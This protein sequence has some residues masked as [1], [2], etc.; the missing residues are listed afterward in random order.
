M[1]TNWN[2]IYGQSIVKEILNNIINSSKIP[3]AILFSG[4]EGTGKDF[5]AVR[6]A[7]ALNLKFLNFD[8][9]QHVNNLISNFSEPYIKYIFPL[10]RGKNESDTTGPMEKLSLDEIQVIKEELSKK[11]QNPYRK[12]KIPRASN[13]K[14]SSIRDIKKFLS[15]DYS[16]VVY[17]IVLIS[18][19]HL[20]NEEA[21]NALLKSLEEPPE[22]V[23][24]ILT[25]PFPNILRETIRSRCWV[26]NFQPLSNEDLTKILISHF[27]FERSLAVKIAPF[28][29]GSV[30]NALML[31]ENEFED[32]LEK[33]ILILRYSF[34]KKF[35]SALNEFAE[36]LADNN[37]ELIKLLINMIIIWL[38]D[39]QKYRYGN[40]NIYFRDY[41]ETIQKF[42]KRFP[43]VSINR[44]VSKLENLA[45]VIRNNINLNLIV[46]NI[47][48]EISIL[49]FPV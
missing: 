20:M 48:Y 1:S 16:D 8:K 18:D 47:V 19:A 42:N 40:E 41:V 24:F 32:L 45:S 39:V 22:G 46:L 12:L 23:I 43:D 36:L 30:N 3:H 14:I 5:T 28:S 38:N 6:F 21:Q 26:I 35:H 31:L 49:T 27:N 4:I 17:R 7:Q 25:T 44:L 33:T 34:G 15:Y 13:I 29:G 10:P 2:G 9:S 37:S 11:I